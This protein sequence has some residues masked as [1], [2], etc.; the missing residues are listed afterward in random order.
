MQRSHFS[1][2]SQ[3]NNIMPGLWEL[4]T[5]KN[6]TKKRYCFCATIYG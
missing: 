2:Q 6:K 3:K 4:Y 5:V 1:L